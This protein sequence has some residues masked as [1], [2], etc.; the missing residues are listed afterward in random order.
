MLLWLAIAVGGAFGAMA[1][2]AL[3]VWVDRMLREP[4]PWGTFIVNAVGSLL[5]GVSAMYFQRIPM[6]P[7]A[8]AFVVVGLLGG[9]TTFSTY[10]YETVLLIR[11]GDV[12]RAGIYAASSVLIGVGAAAIGLVAGS[13]MFPV[14]P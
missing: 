12:L 6:S 9:F 8:R 11:E 1:R 10:S 5:I 13:A 3:T 2:Y 7:E 14:R 4:F